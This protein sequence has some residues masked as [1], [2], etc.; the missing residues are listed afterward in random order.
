MDSAEAAAT[1]LDDISRASY[2]LKSNKAPDHLGNCPEMLASVLAEIFTAKAAKRG[3]QEI[4]AQIEE[5]VQIFCI[6]KHSAAA[7]G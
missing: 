3:Y 2:R 5:M 4:Q 7:R 1:C 6:Q